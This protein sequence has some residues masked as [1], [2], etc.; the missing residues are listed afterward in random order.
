MRRALSGGA[1]LASCVLAVG[2][3]SSPATAPA[4]PTTSA[5]TTASAA[6]G[7]PSPSTPATTPSK[8]QDAADLKKA[9][10]RPADLGKPWTQPEAVSKVKSKKGE[11]CP[12]HVSASG[13][14]PVVAGVVANL[15]QGR[16][17]GKNI[18]TFSLST[19]A[20]EGSGSALAAAYEKDLRACAR[21]RD[22]S[23]LFVV[24]SAEGPSTLAGTELV[25][26]YAERIYY[27]KTHRRLAYA[28]HNLVA[29]QG[30]V[31]TYFS[32]AFLTKKADPRAEDFS[33]ATELLEVQ[34]DKN[35]KV[36]S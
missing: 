24:R 33:T 10:V 7:T 15:T 27:D 21:Y 32:Y 29:R 28:R 18:A 23:G 34:L 14:V 6:P 30:R 8:A 4:K 31:V 19:L 22:G 11:T 25:T 20:E 13:K 16:G 9:L 26:S 36:F 1:I 5:A 3:T 12:G 17:A 2:C 35:A